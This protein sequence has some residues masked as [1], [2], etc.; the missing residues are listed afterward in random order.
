MASRKTAPTFKEDITYKTWK[1]KLSMWTLVTNVPKKEQAIV[2]L[3]EA[4]EGNQKAEKTASNLTATQLNVDGLKVLLDKLDIAFQA[5][6]TD[7]AYSAYTEFNNYKK[8]H[9]TSM[10]DY[11]LEFENL[12][13]KILEYDMKLPDTVLAFKLLDG[14]GLSEQQ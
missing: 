11:I 13:H 7:D 6:T 3:L 2:V 1:N 5:E 14:A 12:Y 8:G 10:N 9:S 4:L